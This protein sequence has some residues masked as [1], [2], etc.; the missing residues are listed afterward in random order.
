MNEVKIREIN[1]V[2]GFCIYENNMPYTYIKTRDAIELLGLVKL[3][4]GYKTLRLDRFGEKFEYVM[5]NEIPRLVRTHIP[6]IG[7]NITENYAISQDCIQE[8]PEFDKLDQELFDELLHS[9]S[10]CPTSG[11]RKRLQNLNLIRPASKYDKY[12]PEYILDRV[13]FMIANNLNNDTAKEFRFNLIW[14]VIPHFQQT[15]TPEQIN[16]VPILNQT[17]EFM[18]DNTNY[19][20][21]TQ[22][23]YN[24]A[25]QV[26]DMHLTRLAVLRK[27]ST[28]NIFLKTNRE[29]N[30]ILTASD[31]YTIDDCFRDYV[32]NMAGCTRHIIP[33]KDL[34]VNDLRDSI[35]CN[36]RIYSIYI[37]FLIQQ[38]REEEEMMIREING[39]H[40]EE[41]QPTSMSERIETRTVLDD[42]NE[43]R[44]CR[45]L[46]LAEKAGRR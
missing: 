16:Q 26:L 9:N 25:R 18:Y 46:S 11:A 4:N 10:S 15:A 20:F 34:T 43:Q 12:I 38:I 37:T 19:T 30:D 24:F 22:Q 40:L 39:E 42:E 1:G 33:E 5:K 3:R 17:V 13:I 35:V 14:T 23:S 27:T 41:Y 31:E 21:V 36:E 8:S 45:F 44:V 29:L 7:I 32:K 2:K 6:K 28:M